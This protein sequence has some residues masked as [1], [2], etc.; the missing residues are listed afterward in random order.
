MT[1]AK[2]AREAAV[3][4]ETVRFYQRRGLIREPHRPKGAD[5]GNHG[6]RRYGSDDL[7]RLRFIKAAQGAGFTLQEI[8]ELLSLDATDDRAEAQRLARA[9]VSALDARIAE[10]KTA[11]AALN[12]LAR[13]CARTN[14]GPCPILSAFE[15]S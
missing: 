7:R 1:I 12:R 11:R 3:G 15:H 14:A 13:R 9:R 6:I 8:G 2:L 10:L 4:V 5:G